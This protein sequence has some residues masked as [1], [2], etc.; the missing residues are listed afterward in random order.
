MGEAVGAAHQCGHRQWCHDA[1][2][3]ADR[4][5]PAGAEGPESNRVQLGG[6]GVQHAPGPQIEEGHEGPPQQDGGGGGGLAE[7][8]GACGAGEQERG[9]RGLAAD[10]FH[11]HGRREIAGQLGQDHHQHVL[12]GLDHGVS[13][14]HQ[15]LGQPGEDAV[16]REHDAEPDQPQH[17]GAAG[18]GRLPELSETDGLMGGGGGHDSFCHDGQA[19][20][21][22]KAR[23]QGVGLVHPAPGQQVGHGFR[24]LFP[25]PEGVEDG[26]RTDPECTV[27]AEVRNEAPRGQRGG[28]PAQAPETFQQHDQPAAHCGGRKFADQRD[29][30]RQ[31]ATQSEAH[32]ES[33]EQQDGQAGRKR[34]QAGGD[35]VE[36]HGAH[37][38]IAAAEA[39]SGPAA[40]HGA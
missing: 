14:L 33:A 17:E 19:G 6:V 2:D 20:L 16:V 1:A 39:V 11:E 27:P 34:A 30:H 9:Q 23:D 35:T 29:G 36:H 3:A 5:C 31:L 8:P 22:F 18:K 37:E 25:D 15:Q 13:L 40:G 10:P 24:Q 21:G 12:E 32:P 38:D 7:E 26:Q 28:Q 4:A